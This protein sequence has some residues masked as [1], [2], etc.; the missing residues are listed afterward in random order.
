MSL[1]VIAVVLGVVFLAAGCGSSSDS[2]SATSPPET[3]ANGLCTS[4]STW[5]KSLTAIVND[6]KGG[7]VTKDSLTSAVDDAKAATD[8]L[9]SDVKDLGA[10]DTASGQQAKDEV[11]QLSTS[12]KDGVATI[13]DS[14][15][16]A[17]GVSGIVQAVSTVGSTVVSMGND[18][19]STLTSLQ[20]LDSKGELKTAFQNA[21]ACS[22]FVG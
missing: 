13:E 10:P 8:T 11:D 2:S 9:A 16:N 4:L 3:W 21:D 12:L 5:Q 22:S 20:Q 6:V 14:V 17:S 7:N 1:R 15:K 18:V 19:K